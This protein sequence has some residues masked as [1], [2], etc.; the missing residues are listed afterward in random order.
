MCVCVC[1]RVC[2]EDIALNNLQGRY[3]L[4]SNQ[5]TSR[6]II[7]T[8]EARKYAKRNCHLTLHSCLYITGFPSISLTIYIYIYLC[9]CVYTILYARCSH[10]ATTVSSKKAYSK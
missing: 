9:V 5:L 4:K 7:L 1:V 8:D 3:T 6:T 2:K 10:K